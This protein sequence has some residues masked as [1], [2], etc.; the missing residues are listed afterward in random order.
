MHA[1]GAPKCVRDSTASAD[2]EVS[3]R[4]WQ[5]RRGAG[6][7]L[8]GSLAP[9]VAW[10]QGPARRKANHQAGETDAEPAAPREGR[11]LS[12]QR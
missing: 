2:P 6:E 12:W 10:G 11:G 8:E 9:A 5:L 1:R 4:P 7:A 3:L